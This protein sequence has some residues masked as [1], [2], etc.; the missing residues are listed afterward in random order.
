MWWARTFEGKKGLSD[1]VIDFQGLT[2]V[3]VSQNQAAVVCD[4]QNQVFI[5]RV[6][7]KRLRNWVGSWF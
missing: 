4:P 3:Q 2:I 5:V 6:C 1:T 7:G